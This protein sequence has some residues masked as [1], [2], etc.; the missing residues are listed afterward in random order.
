MS[1]L[2]TTI[3]IT[4]VFLF[5]NTALM[6]NDSP[7]KARQI[8]DNVPDFEVRTL[9]GRKTTLAALRSDSNSSGITVLTFWCSFCGSCRMVDQPLSDLAEKYSGRVGI[10]ALDSSAGERSRTISRTLKEKN[11]K[12]PVLIDAQ[13]ELADL[14]GARMTT[15]T[16][17]LDAD[18]V[19]RY[20]GQFQRGDQPLAEQAIEALLSGK[21]PAL[22]HTQERG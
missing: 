2:L 4:V 15:T 14:F 6:A 7:K 12:L 22:D 20:W 5:A 11:L 17:I 13:G 21:K 1:R 9:K 16:V 10:W 18:N 8:G 3:L 19:V